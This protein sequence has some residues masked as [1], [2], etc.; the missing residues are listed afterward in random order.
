MV[1][2]GDPDRFLSALTAPQELRGRLMVLYAFNLEV[3]RAPWV[4]RDPLLAEMRLQWWRDVVDGV[5]TANNAAH[6]VAGPLSDLIAAAGLPRSQITALID[7]RRFDI[8]AEPHADAAAQQ[9]YIDTTAGNLMWLAAL[10]LGAPAGAEE[11]VRAFAQGAGTAALLLAVPELTGAQ[12]IPL[13]DAGPDGVAKLAQLGLHQISV[14]RQSR[15]L[16]PKQCNAA[17]L[18]GWQATW[19]LRQA[20]KAPHLVATGGL[21]RSEFGRRASLLWQSATGW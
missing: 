4:A 11:P 8:G 18:A 21:V 19:T 14:A 5:G 3:A 10:A 9:T 17:L 20:Q 13:I 2:K 15:K 7:A 1:R 12:K 6:E 16:L